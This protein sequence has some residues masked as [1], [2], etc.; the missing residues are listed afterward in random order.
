MRGRSGIE[1]KFFLDGSLVYRRLFLVEITRIFRI[2][3]PRLGGRALHELSVICHLH[4]GCNEM[5]PCRIACAKRR[6]QGILKGKMAHEFFRGNAIGLDGASWKWDR[7]RN[8]S[9]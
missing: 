8:K 7:K 2:G 6:L 3:A 1:G 9:L 4:A 5:P